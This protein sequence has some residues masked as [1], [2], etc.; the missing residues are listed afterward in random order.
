MKAHL[1]MLAET[2]NTPFLAVIQGVIVMETLDVDASNWE[3]EIA[4][5]TVLTIVYFWHEQCPWCFRFSPIL[6][7]VAEEYKEKIKFAKLNVLASP[8][9]Q[10]I[11]NNFGVMS[12]PTLLFLCRGRPVGQA[13]GLMSKEDLERGLNDMLA[14]YRGC[15]SKSTE[16]RPAYIV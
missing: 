14:R 1:L 11:A 13:V 9:N 6:E 16:L 12:T 5:S 10:E 8:S 7:E 15:L 2:F 3:P 4:R